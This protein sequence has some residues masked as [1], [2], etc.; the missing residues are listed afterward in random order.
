M[1]DERATKIKEI[2]LRLAHRLTQY[3][4]SSGHVAT[5]DRDLSH[6][7]AEL[8][9]AEGRAGRL[10]EALRELVAIIDAAGLARLSSGVQLG[11]MS[12]LHK[13]SERIEAARDILAAPPEPESFSNKTPTDGQASPAPIPLLL[14]CPLCK[15][16][17]IDRGEFATKPHHTHACQS[18]GHVWRPAIVPT[19]G[20][21]FLP[22]FKDAP[23]SAEG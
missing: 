1:S 3:S 15:G 21:A 9:A 6:A 19:V 18:C 2:R 5:W 22:G 20:V 12:W 10:E 14:W 7:L 11:A 23:E 8:G 16:R 4:G 13:A 17:H